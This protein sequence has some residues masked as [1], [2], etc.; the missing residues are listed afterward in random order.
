M[1]LHKMYGVLGTD[2]YVAYMNFKE[3]KASVQ[4]NNIW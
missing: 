3:N 4:S 1:V 2:T